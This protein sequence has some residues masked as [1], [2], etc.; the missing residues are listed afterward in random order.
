MLSKTRRRWRPKSFLESEKA[1]RHVTT[2]LSLDVLLLLVLI[3]SSASCKSVSQP[4]TENAIQRLM[5]TP[6]VPMVRVLAMPDKFDGGWIK[7]AGLL[8]IEREHTALYMHSDDAKYGMHENSVWV[9]FADSVF[10]DAKRWLKGIPATGDELRDLNRRFVVLGGV[11]DS[12]YNVFNF[13]IALRD[14]N[15]VLVLSEE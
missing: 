14:V 1:M 7:L 3:G 6:A 9:E 11:V 10:L 15:L 4:L 13:T 2:S 5:G 8:V 12:K